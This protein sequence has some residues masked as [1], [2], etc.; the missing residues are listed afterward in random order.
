MIDDN[1]DYIFG[2][3]AEIIPKRFEAIVPAWEALLAGLGI[4]YR[5]EDFAAIH[6]Y[7]IE[8]DYEE[9]IVKILFDLLKQVNTIP[10]TEEK[11]AFIA[12]HQMLG[13]ALKRARAV[14]A[15]RQ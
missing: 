12:E 13:L 15:A 1:K 3:K 8:T 7:V 10:T 2:P 6:Q 5:S 14:V 11:A 4:D 9:D